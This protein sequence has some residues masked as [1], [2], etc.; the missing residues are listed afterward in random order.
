[1]LPLLLLLACTGDSTIDTATVSLNVADEDGDGYTEADGD[2][3]DNNPLIG[4]AALEACDGID[5]DCDG[6]IDE[7]ATVTLYLDADEDGFGNA[8]I[9]TEACT[10]LEGYVLVGS[11]C[12]DTNSD[13]YPGASEVC[14]GE[15]NNCQGAVDEG[16]T[17]TYY[18]DTDSDGF[19]DGDVSTEACA[20][21]DGY[22]ATDTDCD[23]STYTVSPAASEVCDGIDNNCDGDIDE[24]TAVGAPTWY[25]DADSDDYGDPDATTVACDAPIG[26]VDNAD[27]CDDGEDEVYPGA[28]EVCD[29]LN[30][31]CDDE[32]DEPSATDA[33]TFYADSDG[34]GYGSSV[35]VVACTAPS[36]FVDNDD[37]CN[38]GDTT[39]YDGAEEI[40]DEQDNDC[41]G[42]ID[43]GVS[44]T[45]YL[46]Y[47]ADGYGDDSYAE[48]RCTAPGAL[49][50]TTGGDCNDT[51]TAY[52]PDASEGCDGEDYNC[53]GDVDSDADGDGFA[54]ATCGGDDCDDADA[55]T[56]PTVGGGC[57]MGASCL[58]ILDA[59]RSEG[60]DVYTIDI[61]GYETGED[62][63]EVYCDMTSDGG[64]W[65][66]LAK[67]FKTGLTSDERSTIRQGTWADYTTTGYGDPDTSSRIYWMPLELWYQL[68]ALYPDNELW[69]ED[70]S[71]NLKME[72][73][74][75]SD[76]TTNYTIDWDDAVAGYSDILSGDIRGLPFTTYDSD[77]DS[78]TSGNCAS[79]YVGYNGGFWYDSCYET[80]MLNADSSIYSWA[81]DAVTSVSYLYIY[82][83]EQ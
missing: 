32:T 13:S 4:P 63:F 53:D 36:G 22:V 58:D 49:Y 79:D 18:A 60:D 80:S 45:W 76:S 16:V 69:I 9:S 31:D 27:D 78:W 15:D 55:A 73:A 75:I 35:E 17:T 52:S 66:L 23:D 1:M 6:E 25:A 38:D 11:D 74:S 39:I 30:N 51:S 83:R 10:Q 40:C 71:T 14:D 26:Y 67:T 62:P 7:G 64:G 3:A 43:E 37:D 61:D 29:G 65:T 12:D 28:E 21:P 54:D 59:D 82:F 33:E 81:D 2:C 47:D 24:V 50:V 72:D 70:S 44:Q 5:N 34:D 42:D 19:G 56:S 77:N 46:D 20:A 41:D 68:T 57:A 48:T 8:D